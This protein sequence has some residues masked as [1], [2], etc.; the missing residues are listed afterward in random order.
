MCYYSLFDSENGSDSEYELMEPTIIDSTAY[1]R[2]LFP[3]LMLSFEQNND[4]TEIENKPSPPVV[5]KKKNVSQMGRRKANR[6][7]NGTH[8]FV[9]ARAFT[10]CK[11]S[12]VL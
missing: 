9:Y 6:A 11:I 2:D 1:Y 4:R 10:N 12:H 5:F 3:D 8:I 7:Q